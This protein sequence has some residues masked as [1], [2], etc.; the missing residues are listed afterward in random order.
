MRATD[1]SEHVVIRSEAGLRVEDLKGE[2]REHQP[3]RVTLLPLLGWDVPGITVDVGP[4]HRGNFV[5]PLPGEQQHPNHRAEG[6]IRFG[7]FPHSPQFI[8]VKNA[9]ALHHCASMHS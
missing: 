9:L 3:T 6:A 8:V 7:Y 1:A 4:A 2:G 5:A